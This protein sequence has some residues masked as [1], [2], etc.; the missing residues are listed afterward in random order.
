VRV[1]ACVCARA[2]V[3]MR[4]RVCVCVR[5][6]ACVC[7]CV[8]VCGGGIVK[9]SAPLPGFIT[10]QIRDFQKEGRDLECEYLKCSGSPGT[11]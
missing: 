7:A 3:C 5:A 8:C 11:E 10:Q 4:A 6:R 1:R 2:C 9:K